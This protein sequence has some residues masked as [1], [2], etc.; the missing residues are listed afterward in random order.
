MLGSITALLVAL[1]WVERAY[2]IVVDSLLPLAKYGN[3]FTGYGWGVMG[4]LSVRVVI[5]GAMF[6]VF[7]R[8]GS[9][10]PIHL[11]RIT[12]STASASNA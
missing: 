7:A 4:S 5:A 10:K 12:H 9:R 2:E 3:Q 6:W 8:L 1:F 11:P